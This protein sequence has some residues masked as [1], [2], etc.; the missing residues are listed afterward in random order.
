[1]HKI[2][3]ANMRSGGVVFMKP[4]RG[5]ILVYLAPMVLNGNVDV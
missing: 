2:I 3:N 5:S 1:M 4:L